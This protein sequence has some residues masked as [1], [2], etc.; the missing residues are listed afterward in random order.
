MKDK[1]NFYNLTSEEQDI[2]LENLWDNTLPDIKESADN[3]KEI[4]TKIEY[5]YVIGL[6][7][8]Y[9]MGKTYFSSRFSAYLN[10]DI[11]TMSIYFSAWEYDIYNDPFLAFSKVILEHIKTT[12]EVILKKTTK[13][14]KKLA[15][16]TNITTNI[17]FT[18]ISI[19]IDVGRLIDEFSKGKNHVSEFKLELTNILNEIKIKKLIII[20]DELD[21]CRP[22]Y[23]IKVLETIKHFFDIDKIIFLLPINIETL[24]KAVSAVYGFSD[25]TSAEYLRKFF[26]HHIYLPSPDYTKFITSILNKKLFEKEIQARYLNVPNKPYTNLESLQNCLV[27]Y[28]T[29][30]KPS[31]RELN[32]I[33][34]LVELFVKHKKERIRCEILVYCL[35]LNFKKNIKQESKNNNL[36]QNTF[37]TKINHFKYSWK[38]YKN[39]V[40]NIKGNLYR[41]T[42]TQDEIKRW[43]T[44][45][46][47]PNQIQTYEDILNH[48]NIIQELKEMIDA[49]SQIKPLIEDIQA[50]IDDG[51]NQFGVF[52]LNDIAFTMPK[53]DEYNQ[54]VENLKLK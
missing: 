1:S 22:D 25:N 40:E 11:N 36:Q 17:P 26:N 45:F 20:V 51:I 3:L 2:E 16:T 21:R 18:P 38:S 47:K 28:A 9:G 53:L 24:V 12:K 32:N 49:Y 27:N 19:N 10:K 39:I 30:I 46:Q 41:Y 54:F 50:Y 52:E 13:C 29:E 33:L 14:F 23:A 5:P 31:L 37:F 6:N 4:L 48:T 44:I 7:A 15:K 42:F 34:N 35:F 8:G 43:E